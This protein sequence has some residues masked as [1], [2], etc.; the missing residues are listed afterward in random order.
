MRR[1]AGRR[2]DAVTP[3]PKWRSQSRCAPAAP[4]SLGARRR[5]CR[6]AGSRCPGL[7]LR[8][9]ARPRGPRAGPP[10]RGRDQRVAGAARRRAR[11]ILSCILR[12]VCGVDPQSA[13]PQSKRL[14]G[15]RGVYA[16]VR[17]ITRRRR[18]VL[19]P[20]EARCE[21][22][23]GLVRPGKRQGDFAF[24]MQ[25]AA[26]SPVECA[27]GRRVHCDS[28]AS[29]RRFPACPVVNGR[30]T[31]TQCFAPLTA[32]RRSSERSPRPFMPSRKAT[33]RSRRS[34]EHPKPSSPPCR[35]TAA[36]TRT[37]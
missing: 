4:A 18:R 10:P 21:E 19:A 37:V 9:R 33:L 28:V 5:G 25:G 1:V 20:H 3:T 11:S 2:G 6:R 17:V 8:T 13:S 7:A 29:L 26:T 14:S 36:D 16:T 32:L 34:D 35:E 22:D 24:H 30:G 12:A 23:G 31:Q 27:Y 15:K